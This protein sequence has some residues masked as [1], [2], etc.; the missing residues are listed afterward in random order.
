[1]SLKFLARITRQTFKIRKF[2]MKQFSWW[3]QELEELKLDIC[4]FLDDTTWRF[5]EPNEYAEVQ[6]R[7]L[8]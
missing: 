7:C 6:E 8:G 3:D 1:M 4:E 5:Q 2:V